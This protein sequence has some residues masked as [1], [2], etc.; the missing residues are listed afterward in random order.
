MSKK[1]SSSGHKGVRNPDRKNGKAYKKHP[2][3]FSAEKRRLV[4][5]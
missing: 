4:S 1:R 3:I 2:K 5:L